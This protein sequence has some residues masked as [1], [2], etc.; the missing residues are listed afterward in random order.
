MSKDTESIFEK[1][2]FSA[3]RPFLKSL[4]ENTWILES[5][6]DQ[7]SL[8]V[9]LKCDRSFLIPFVEYAW[10]LWAIYPVKTNVFW[11]LRQFSIENVVIFARHSVTEGRL[12]EKFWKMKHHHYDFW[13]KT[14]SISF[15]T[16]HF[17]WRQIKQ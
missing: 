3:S 9:L 10:I 15:L 7:I 12:C 5:I 8:Q 14:N 17:L 2:D 11:K 13:K 1:N 16:E 6:F 4:L